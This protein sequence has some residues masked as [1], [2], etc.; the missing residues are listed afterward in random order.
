MPDRNPFATERG[1]TDVRGTTTVLSDIAREGGSQ[2]MERTGRGI[3]HTAF[4][5]GRAMMLFYG[6]AFYALRMCYLRRGWPMI[7]RQIDS[8]GFGSLLVLGLITGLT[9]MIMAV[10]TGSALEQYN[11]TELT[12]G[13]IAVTFCRELGPIWAAVIMLARVGAAMAAELG[14]MTVNEEIDALRAM[15]ISPVRY[16]VMPRLVALALVMPLLAVVGDF[17]GILGGALVCKPAFNVNVNVFFAKAQEMLTWIDVFSGLAKSVVFGCLIAT[18]A[19]DQGLNT[20]D[21]A[22]GV[23][24]STTRAVVLSVIFV[25]VSDLVMTAFVQLTVVR[26][27]SP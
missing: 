18:I 27:V 14:T 17:I 3:L 2:M 11:Q 7:Q 19:C 16:L 13:I 24:R 8:A 4:N 5:A 26:M 15:S 23:G 9:G 25:L 1:T 20:T 6:A 22:E 21:G 10:Q 12:G